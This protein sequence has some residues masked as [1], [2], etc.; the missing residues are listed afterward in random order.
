MSK[1]V[2]TG[3][4]VSLDIANKEFGNGSSSFMN[5]QGKYPDPATLDNVLIDGLDMYF[6]AF[7]SLLA[8]RYATGLL[9]GPDFKDTGTKAEAKYQ[10]IRTFLLKEQEQEQPTSVE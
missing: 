3:I 6:A 4:T 7:K 1:P 2:I 5:I 8:S 10:K 9:S